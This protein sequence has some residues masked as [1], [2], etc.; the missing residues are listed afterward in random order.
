MDTNLLDIAEKAVNLAERQGADQAEVYI[1]RIQSFEIEAENNAIKY[2][3]ERIDAG[4]GIRTIVG[5]KI[6]FAY[7][8]TLDDTDIQEAVSN[9]LSLARASIPDPDFVSLPDYSS[10][11][12]QTRGL[13]D[14]RIQDLTSEEAAEIIIRIID[15][16]KQ[17]LVD[18]DYAIEA[19]VYTSSSSS[20]IVNSL[21]I[22]KSESKTFISV[23]GTSIIKEDGD[24]TLSY[25]YQL[26]RNFDDIDPEWVGESSA[27]LAI[28]ALHPKTIEG[29][30]MPVIFAPLGASA[31]LGRGFAGAINAEEVQMGRS[32]IADAFGEKIASDKLEIIDDG[33][34]PSGIGS[35]TYDAEGYRS[36]RTV[37]IEGGVLKS[38][39]HNSY[40]ANK[41]DV[42][43]TGNASRPSYS[44]LPSISTSNFMVKPGKGD[45]EEFI[46]ETKRGVV[47]RN[48][49]DLPNMTT[50]D[51]SAMIMEGYYIEDGEIQHALKNTL[52][53]I[54]MKQLLQRIAHVGNDIRTASAMI[55][56]SLVIER[57]NITSG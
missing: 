2:A 51:L 22:S 8:T 38:L 16:S 40:T 12:H 32:Y 29:G 44:G 6:G 39:L 55:T 4:I 7:V 18:R 9:S 27:S 50:G 11:Y 52:I 25:D 45:L 53:G 49:G 5:K 19:A 56:P 30:E 46:S 42:E 17:L 47:C 13:F 24:Q 21:G 37:I 43:N 14:K 34:L 3:S 31:I 15:T 26:S 36:Q 23:N 28:K 1:G 10:D 57:A 48:T 35:R 41:D 20:A 33:V 54:N